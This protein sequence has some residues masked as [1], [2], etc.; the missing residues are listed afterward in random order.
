MLKCGN[1]LIRQ[2]CG[3]RSKPTQNTIGNENGDD[4]EDFEGQQKSERLVECL[5]FNFIQ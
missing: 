2:S 4:F 3:K 1:T 5:P